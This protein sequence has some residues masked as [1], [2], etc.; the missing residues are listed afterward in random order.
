MNRCVKN[1]G[2]Q[3]QNGVAHHSMARP[4]GCTF[5]PLCKSLD[6]SRSQQETAGIPQ[7][8]FLKQL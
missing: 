4:L 6:L 5:F 2:P 3:E 7:L 1:P 8:E